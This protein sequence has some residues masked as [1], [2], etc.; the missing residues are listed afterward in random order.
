MSLRRDLPWPIAPRPFPDEAMGSWF[1]RLAARYRMSVTEFAEQNDITLPKLQPTVGWLLMPPLDDE[2][3]DR[4][5]ELAR[6]SRDKI[7]A[8]QTP[9]EWITQ[10][11]Y[12]SLCPTCL[13]LN[14]EDI[15][16]PRWLRDWLAPDFI[17]CRLHD[18]PTITIS[19]LYF[20]QCRNFSDVLRLVGADEIWNAWLDRDR[21]KH[22]IRLP[23]P[24]RLGGKERIPT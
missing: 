4:I 1:G 18:A 7:E 17:P 16:A 14:R 10:R 11:W 2:S 24:T 19:T 13:F 6:L 22:V 20:A 21:P 8:I 23:K 15:S 9:S 5:A 3:M 12:F